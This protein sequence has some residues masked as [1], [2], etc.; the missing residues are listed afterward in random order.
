RPVVTWLDDDRGRPGGSNPGQEAARKMG[1]RLR[2]LGKKVCNA[3]SE[4][5]PKY[6]TRSTID[7]VLRCAS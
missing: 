4:R 6:L 2:A 7:E 3:T 5:D 1:Q